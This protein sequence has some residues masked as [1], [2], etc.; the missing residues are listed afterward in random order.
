MSTGHCSPPCYP[1]TQLKALPTL[2]MSPHIA[3]VKAGRMPFMTATGS[4]VTVETRS[5][6]LVLL[7]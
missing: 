3:E 6:K 7:S 1:W 4:G 2:N 5:E